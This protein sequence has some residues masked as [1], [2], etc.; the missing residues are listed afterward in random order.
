[1]PD[2]PPRR[3]VNP[4]IA[5]SVV[6]GAEMFF[7]RDDVFA[8][9]RRNLIGQHSN[10]PIVLYGQ[11]RTGK[12]SALYQLRRHLGPE[13]WCVFIDLHALTLGGVHSR[14]SVIGC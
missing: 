8:F 13:Y 9:I 11:R 6:S 14:G 7:G 2:Q 1:M 5:G 12:T 4:Y 10:H 3:H